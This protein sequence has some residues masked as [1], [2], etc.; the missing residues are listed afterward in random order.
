MRDSFY[1]GRVL[2]PERVKR[3]GTTRSQSDT[4]GRQFGNCRTVPMIVSIRKLRL[5]CAAT[6]EQCTRLAR[7]GLIE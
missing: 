2:D 5:V 6:M 7:C 1:D 4:R 3:V